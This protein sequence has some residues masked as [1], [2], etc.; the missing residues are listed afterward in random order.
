ML[1]EETIVWGATAM[2]LSELEVI[3]KEIFD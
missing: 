1:P 3:L 2:I